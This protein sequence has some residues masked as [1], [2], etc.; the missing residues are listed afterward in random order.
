MFQVIIVCI[1]C[2][3]IYIFFLD[4]EIGSMFWESPNA[5]NSKQMM[6]F[7]FLSTSGL[8]SRVIPMKRHQSNEKQFQ[9]N[10]THNNSKLEN[11]WWHCVPSYHCLYHVFYYLYIFSRFRNWFNVLGVTKR[12]KF[13]TNDALPLP[14][15][16]GLI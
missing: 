13:K 3:I 2:F 6:L 8:Y 1:M 4:F 9:T 7:H 10:Q 12:C 16:L 5:A 14:V 15:Y 11:Q